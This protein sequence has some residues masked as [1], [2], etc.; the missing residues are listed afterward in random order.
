M[1]SG[2]GETRILFWY[3]IKERELKAEESM[4]KEGACI[5]GINFLNHQLKLNVYL[6]L[7]ENFIA[8]C[9]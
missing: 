4:A 2:S 1:D 7:I 3:I 8:K 5:K 6:D 9:Q